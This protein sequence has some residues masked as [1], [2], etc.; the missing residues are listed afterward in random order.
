MKNDSLGESLSL[1]DDIVQ[2]LGR[3]R[4]VCGHVA[5]GQGGQLVSHEQVSPLLPK[6]DVNHMWR[7]ARVASWFLMNRLVLCCLIMMLVICGDRPGSPA[8]FS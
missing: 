7:Q 6:Y 1:T 3:G 5:T 4:L 2:G 8:G